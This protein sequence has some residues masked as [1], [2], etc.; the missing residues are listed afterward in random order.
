MNCWWSNF[1][2]G[3][4]SKK[5]CWTRQ[6]WCSLIWMWSNWTSWWMESTTTFT[7]GNCGSSWGWSTRVSSL[8]TESSL[9]LV[10]NQIWLSWVSFNDKWYLIW[11]L[12]NLKHSLIL[13]INYMILVYVLLLSSKLEILNVIFVLN[14]WISFWLYSLIHYDWRFT[15]A[16]EC[17]V[18]SWDRLIMELMV[19]IFFFSTTINALNPLL[20]AIIL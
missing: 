19:Q 13:I 20:V 6:S 1:S 15:V 16:G 3:F 12:F 18:R 5:S 9:W 8:L 17:F 14:K 2:L 11:R 10:F 4:A 7:L